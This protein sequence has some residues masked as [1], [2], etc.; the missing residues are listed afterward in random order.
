M[1]FLGCLATLKL[2]PLLPTSVAVCAFPSVT[3]AAAVVRD[4]IQ[5]GVNVACIEL[6]DEVMIKAINL[7]NQSMGNTRHWE[8]K[9]SLFLKFSGSEATI[10]GD[11]EAVR[12]LTKKNEGSKFEFA[13]NEVDAEEI[14]Y[15]RKVRNL[16][17]VQQRRSL[18][19]FCQSD[20]VVECVRIIARI[21][22]LDY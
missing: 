20:R 14:W 16:C 22:M 13:K 21:Q 15:S 1:I 7:K 11:I 9:P 5:G 2:S 4:V 6:L 18:N 17:Y 19:H 8:E 12:L 3:A 10:K